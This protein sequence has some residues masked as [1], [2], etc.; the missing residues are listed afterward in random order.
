MKN[1]RSRVKLFFPL[2]LLII[3]IGGT[4]WQARPVKPQ[5]PASKPFVSDTVKP[6][7]HGTGEN[8]PGIDNIDRAMKELEQ[9]MKK[10][11]EEMKQVDL[12]KMETELRV[13]MS[14]LDASKIRSEIKAAMEKIDKRRIREEIE[15]SLRAADQGLREID[16]SKMEAQ[17]AEVGKNL[18]KQQK[19]MH[20]EMENVQKHVTEAMGKAKIQMQKAQEELKHMRAFTDELEKD[21]LID[22]RKGYKVQV[23]Q[24][25]LYINGTKQ[26]KETSDKYRK[27]Y[28]Q[29]DFTIN[30][31]GESIIDL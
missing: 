8:E 3:L 28:K 27:Y 4:A 26:S 24:G 14:K 16:F 2:F 31:N 20:L 25:E 17:L 15:N 10:L 13:A 18:E 22:K 11:D 6:G 9:S 1:V 7:E 5:S 23:K 30:S 19:Q 21:G 12:S 29:D